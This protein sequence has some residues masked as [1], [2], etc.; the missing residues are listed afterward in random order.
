[1]R[2]ARVS[3]MG[4]TSLQLAFIGCYIHYFDG[5]IAM[6]ATFGP[7]RGRISDFQSQMLDL[8]HA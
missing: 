2:G 6:K 7:F 4:L 3:G 5:V 8:E 1:M